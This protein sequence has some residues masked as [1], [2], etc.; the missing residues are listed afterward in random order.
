M[1]SSP[2]LCIFSYVVVLDWY[3]L[4]NRL[5]GSNISFHFEKGA[6]RLLRTW[7]NLE[8]W[9]QLNKDHAPSSHF[10][11]SGG[12]NPANLIFFFFFLLNIFPAYLSIFN[13]SIIFFLAYI[14]VEYS[15]KDCI[16]SVSVFS[17]KYLHFFTWILWGAL[18]EVL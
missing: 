4:D 11:Q 18:E 3:F 12:G 7:R 14:V 15:Q 5:K 17:L 10:L 1:Y 9:E 8:I 2:S 16:N 6:K 13:L